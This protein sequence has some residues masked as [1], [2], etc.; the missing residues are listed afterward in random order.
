MPVIHMQY[1]DGTIN[2][3][4]KTIRELFT[5]LKSATNSIFD[6]LDRLYRDIHLSNVVFDESD[7]LTIL[8]QTPKSSQTNFIKINENNDMLHHDYERQYPSFGA[9][10]NYSR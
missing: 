6:I 4:F 3:P 10:N 5:L 8:N 1:D 7:V 9:D 2:I